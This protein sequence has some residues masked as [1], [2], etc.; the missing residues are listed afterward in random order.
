MKKFFISLIL[1]GIC[2]SNFS[3]FASAQEIE[4]E[5]RNSYYTDIVFDSI[6]KEKT[7][8]S[9]ADIDL[10]SN[11]PIVLNQKILEELEKETEFGEKYPSYFS[12]TYLNNS[13]E[14]V[15]LLKD[16]SLDNREHIKDIVNGESLKF[17]KATY[18]YDELY[19]LKCQ[20]S[21]TIIQLKKNTKSNCEEVNSILK[22]CVGV[23]IIDD[24][25]IVAVD[26]LN[27]TQD[28]VVIFKKYIMDSPMITFQSSDAI[29]ESN[30]N[31][32][33]FYQG[34]CIYNG[35]SGGSCSIGFRAWKLKEDGT[36]AYGFVTAG[37]AGDVGDD[38]LWAPIADPSTVIGTVVCSQISGSVDA[39]FVEFYYGMATYTLDEYAYYTN[40]DGGTSST[41]DKISKNTYFVSIPVGY[42]V[43]KNG[44][45]TYRTSGTV[46]SSSYDTTY[47]DEDY[48]ITDM[49]QTN[50]KSDNGDSGGIV[51]ALYE[52]NA[53]HYLLL[54]IHVASNSFHI[55]AINR[56]AYC[57]KIKNIMNDLDVHLH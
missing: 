34:Q 29:I 43:F 26:I 1:T 53:P 44:K 36:Y 20:I 41:K 52:E 46:K 50:Y 3:L 22:D 6:E 18:S 2:L 12:G 40:D 42:E 57:V 27:L 32:Q 45:T 17:E 24:K 55:G 19:D 25:N 4:H 35:T 47:G 9:V 28:K 37:H 11:D 33:T 31:D 8:P 56:R 30:S 15:V 39:A 48:Y 14:F 21:D 23:G 49:I 38:M 51:Y 7:D 54:G 13:G 10:P 16:S 5:K